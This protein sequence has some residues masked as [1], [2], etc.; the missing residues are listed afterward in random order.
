MNNHFHVGIWDP[1]D[2]L[3]LGRKHILYNAGSI[4]S[5]PEPGTPGPIPLYMDFCP[6][7]VPGHT[8]ASPVS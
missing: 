4:K 8:L 3:E 2:R 7:T 1:G 5:P 6:R